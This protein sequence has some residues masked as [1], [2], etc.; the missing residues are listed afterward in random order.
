MTAQ[1]VHEQLKNDEAYQHSRKHKDYFSMMIV[2][3]A[4]GFNSTLDHAITMIN[5]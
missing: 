3:R 1:Q 2:L 4:H 5:H